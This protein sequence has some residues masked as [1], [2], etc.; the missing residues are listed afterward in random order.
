MKLR[1]DTIQIERTKTYLERL[2]LRVDISVESEPDLVNYDLVHLFNITRAYETYLQYLNARRQGKPVALSPI[3]QDLR[4]YNQKGRHGLARA[5]YTL[6]PNEDVIEYLK[7][8]FR[9]FSNRG[10]RKAIRLHRR[11]GY[12]AQQKEI[13]SQTDILLPNSRMERDRIAAD[14]G[15]KNRYHVVPNGVD[16]TFITASPES[17]I[18]RYDLRNFVLC[19]GRIESLK[20]QLSLI[21]A[22]KD[23]GL[24]LILIGELNPYHGLYS[25]KVLREIGRNRKMFYLSGLSQGELPSAY[26]AARVHVQPSWF[27]TSGLASLEAGL[28]GCN[29]VLTSR[30]Y[31]REYFKDYAWYCDPEDTSSIHQAVLKAYHSPKRRGLKKHILQ[32]YTWEKAAKETRKAYQEI[33]ER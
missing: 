16:H 18:T 22:L 13:L 14:F 19:A 20:N 15:V 17:F 10:Q 5:A 28:V 4:E 26:A 31:A 25:R 6:I 12:G 2:G 21:R 27:E 11:M 3:Y 32:N 23:S 30:G 33:L 7:N 1:G 9:N 8:I 24:T 29:I